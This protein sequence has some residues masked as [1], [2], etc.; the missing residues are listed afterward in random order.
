LLIKTDK[1]KEAVEKLFYAIDANEPSNI[2]MYV[3]E[4]NV[5]LQIMLRDFAKM[6]CVKTIKTYEDKDLYYFEKEV[7]NSKQFGGLVFKDER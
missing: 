4:Y 2:T 7:K 1:K 6:K 3:D 5:D